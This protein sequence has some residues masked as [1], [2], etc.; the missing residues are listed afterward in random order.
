MRVCPFGSCWGEIEFV[1]HSESLGLGGLE[2]AKDGDGNAD[3]GADIHKA[4]SRGHDLKEHAIEDHS[5]VGN[6]RKPYPNDV[7]IYKCSGSA[8]VAAT[9]AA[10]SAVPD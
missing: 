1:A 3:Y 2:L 10:L 4:S 8:F 6:L 5:I 7:S 9:L